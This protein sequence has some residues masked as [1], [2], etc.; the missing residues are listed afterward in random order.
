MTL[1]S[2]AGSLNYASH[3]QPPESDLEKKMNATCG[4]KC[5]ES[6]GRF[7]HVGLW[8]KTFSALLI[9]TGDWY[10]TRCKLT[11][12]LKGTKYNRLYFQL[13]ASTLP[14]KETGFGLLPTPT[15]Q[16]PTSECEIN[17]NGRRMTTNGKDSHSLNIGRMA[18][19]GLLL[20]PTTREEVVDLDKFKKRMEKYPNGTTMPNL[21]TQVVGMLPTPMASEGEK[22]TGSPSE[23][24]M[25]LTKLAR[26]GMLPT[27]SALDWIPPRKP[28]TFILAQERHKQKGVSL[29][30]P[31]KQMAVMGMLPTP[32]QRD[33]LGCTKPGT[34]IT[35]TGKTQT[36]GEVLPDTVKRITSSTSQLNPLFVEEMM[37]FPENWTLLPFLNGEMSQSKD[38]ETPSCPK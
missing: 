8:A 7:N 19:M 30:N 25:S 21:A 13:Q 36:Y 32:N 5:A 33:Y 3:T 11:W 20:T 1:F 14:T 26:N 2:Q 31:L 23:N 35:S 34:R 24:Q 29:Q 6:F 28:E 4:P 27:P 17:E 38:L 12:K 22:L 9:G 18:A 15:T 37:G 10:S 16:E